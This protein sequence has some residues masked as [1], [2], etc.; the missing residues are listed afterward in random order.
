MTSLY[1]CCVPLSC[2][3]ISHFTDLSL[4]HFFCNVP[5]DMNQFQRFLVTTL[6]MCHCF[7]IFTM[8]TKVTCFVLFFKKRELAFTLAFD[9]RSQ[10]VHPTHCPGMMNNHG[11]YMYNL[12]PAISSKI[13]GRNHFAKIITCNL[14]I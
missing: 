4:F 8:I 3:A 9:P 11:K 10:F 5:T 13:I 7:K 14:N 1:I 2:Q 12:N 6:S